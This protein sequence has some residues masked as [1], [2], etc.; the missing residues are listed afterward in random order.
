MTMSA[1]LTVFKKEMVD[2]LR[3]GRSILISMIY[4]LMGPLLLGLMF[5]FVG[6]GMRV[7]DNGPLLVPIVH[8]DSAP[9]LVRFLENEGATMQDLFGD[10]RGQV[11]GGRVAFAL[12]LPERPDVTSEHAAVR[13]IRNPSRVDRMV[14][15]AGG[16]L[17]N[18]ISG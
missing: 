14:A 8:R 4:P 9:D 18:A 2:H 3:D 11:L 1:I 15:T 7:T 6:G 16:Q 5:L 17:L 13:L 12:I 10:A